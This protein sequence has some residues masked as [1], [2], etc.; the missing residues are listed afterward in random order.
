MKITGAISI[1]RT[2]SNRDPDVITLVLRDETS[3]I[4]FVEVKMS[5]EAFALAVTGL[6]YQPCEIETDGLEHVGMVKETRSHEFRLG[7]EV[8]DSDLKQLAIQEARRTCPKGWLLSDS[9]SSQD[10]FFRKGEQTWARCT[11][12][13]YVAKEGAGE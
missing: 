13:R 6:A 9:F 7:C 12:R 5:L 4:N 11:I 10:S 3:R 2:Q 8:Y 1:H